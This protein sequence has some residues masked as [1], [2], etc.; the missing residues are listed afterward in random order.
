MESPIIKIGWSLDS[1]RCLEEAEVGLR[2]LLYKH[3]GQPRLATRVCPFQREGQEDY[4]R[5]LTTFSTLSLYF[6]RGM[7]TAFSPV[8][9]R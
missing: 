5:R 3:D 1:L 2:F 4:S 6:I 7:T 8:R 9:T